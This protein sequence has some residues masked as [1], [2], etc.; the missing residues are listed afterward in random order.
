[1]DD[2]TQ[3][4]SAYFDAQDDVAL[5]VLFGS[6][7][8]E[9]ERTDSDVDIA[10]LWQPRSERAMAMPVDRRME[11]VSQ[12]ALRTGRAVDL[13]DLASAGLPILGEALTTGRTLAARDPDIRA[14]LLVRY[15]I[16]AADFMP[17][18][19]RILSERR[20]AWIG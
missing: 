2:R 10:V 6:Y 5:A 13:V 14:T 9:R 8:T 16:D 17:Y 20:A 18:Y 11:I 1:M 12:L 15:L 19:E 4:L 7:G 3:A